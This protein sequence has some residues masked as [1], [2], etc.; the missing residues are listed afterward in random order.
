MEESSSD[1]EDEQVPEKSDL[2][3]DDSDSDSG[4]DDPNAGGAK[5]SKVLL[6]SDS[7][8]EPE[9]TVVKEYFLFINDI[10]L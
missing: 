1:Q 5:S 9:H 8:S 10:L 7:D 4:P 2:F 3:G 6:D